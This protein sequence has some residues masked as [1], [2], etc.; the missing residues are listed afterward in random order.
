MPDQS[1]TLTAHPETTERRTPLAGQRRGR[2]GSTPGKYSRSSER[3][4]L[5]TC[6]RFQTASYCARARTATAW[7]SS[8]SA[9]SGR[10]ISMSVRMMLASM[11]ASPGSDFFAAHAVTVAIA[12]GRHRIDREDLAGTLPQRGDQQPAAGLDRH[13]DRRLDVS[14]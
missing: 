4:W 6:C 7:A 11:R 8:V 3:S 5:Q 1:G 2:C 9:A 13:W 14:P 12:G 10:C